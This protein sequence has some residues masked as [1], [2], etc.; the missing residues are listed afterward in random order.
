MAAVIEIAVVIDH[1][2]HVQLLLFLSH[3]QVEELGAI[4]K[5]IQVNLE[6]QEVMVAPEVWGLATSPDMSIHNPR[7]N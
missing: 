6:V 5:I 3:Q 4:L 1:A 7:R 2:I